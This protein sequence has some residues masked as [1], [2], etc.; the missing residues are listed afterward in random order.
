[1]L[2]R[3]KLDKNQWIEI[4]ALIPALVFIFLTMYYWDNQTIFVATL[5]T[6]KNIVTAP[7]PSIFTSWYLPYGI[8]WQLLCG[9][10]TIPVLILNTLGL[11]SVTSVG[12]RL[13]YKLFLVIFMILDA[14]AVGRIA[15]IVYKDDKYVYW[16]KMFFLSSMFVVISALQ[17]GQLDVACLL[18]SLL[19]VE[20]Y[21]EKKHWKFLICFALANPAK[22]F[23]LFI[24]IPLVLFREKRYIYIIRDQAVG[25]SVIFV[26]KIWK[27]IGSL[28]QYSEP[29]QTVAAA[30]TETVSTTENVNDFM[31]SSVSSFLSQEVTLFRVS[32]SVVVLA[33][34]LFCI[35][36]YMRHEEEQ[37][38]DN[39]LVIS[40]CAIG[41]T[42]LFA[43]GVCSPYWLVLWAPF[44]V[45]LS[46]NRKEYI[47]ILLPLEAIMAISFLYIYVLDAPWVL[48]SCETFDNLMISLIPSY[49]STHHS[50]IKDFMAQR[51]IDGF[52]S[53]FAAA[54][55]ACCIGMIY[56]TW[57]YRK[58]QNIIVEEKTTQGY[59]KFWYWIRVLVLYAWIV[60]NIGVVI[61][62]HM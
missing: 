17:I 46:L 7:V 59:V 14:Q 31:Q 15:R 10:W 22:Y 39:Q 3:I 58:T 5:T 49:F 40:I 41:F 6:V 53:V 18:A 35:W 60:L 30:G 23:A 51:G 34:A 20:A 54:W 13:W 61:Y 45:L 38:K 24:F 29:V 50:Y 37:E 55:A 42:I 2:K 44:M 25:V 56:I 16:A 43:L 62:N 21:L 33:F 48:G 32:A 57:P 12:A 1:M 8:V 26:E 9:I 27:H 36:T 47:Q 11:C 4:I 28:L 19:G 52:K